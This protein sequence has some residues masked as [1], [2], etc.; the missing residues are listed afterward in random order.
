ML[1]HKVTGLEHELLEVISH[2]IRLHNGM[3][4]T[5]ETLAL[6]PIEDT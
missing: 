6:F 5:P 3:T 2:E 1:T 4:V